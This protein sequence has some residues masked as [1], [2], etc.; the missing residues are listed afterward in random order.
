ME[1]VARRAGTDEGD[2]LPEGHLRRAA[3]AVLL[4]QGAADVV[5]VVLAGRAVPLAVLYRHRLAADAA[6]HGDVF[7]WFGLHLAPL[8]HAVHWAA[9]VIAGY[10]LVGG[11]KRERG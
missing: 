6:V 2:L 11:L 7:G 3:Q 5:D 8:G 10:Q 9:R 1:A 4:R